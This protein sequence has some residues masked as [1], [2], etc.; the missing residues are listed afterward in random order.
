MSGPFAETLL[1]LAGRIRAREVTSTAVTE[2]CL[3]RIARGNARVNAF[4]TVSAEQALAMAHDA[5]REIAL[6]RYRGPLHGVPVSFKDLVDV[7]GMPT[8]AASRLLAGRVAPSDAPVAARLRAAGAVFLGKTNLHEFAFG[9]TSEDSAYGPVRNPVDPSR[10]AGGSSGGAAAA[11]VEGMGYAAIGTDTG[12]S[13]RI[14]AAACGCVGLKPTF[15]EIACD[16]VIPLS[17]SLD[18]VG[19][20]AGS[21]GGARAT[22]EAALG[23]PPSQAAPPPLASLRIG[24]LR[25]Y[26]TE[27]LDEDVRTAFEAVLRRLEAAGAALVERAVP[28][29]SDVASIYL[30]VQLP[31]ASA[32]HAEAI[33]QHPDAYTK[34]VRLRLEMGR[35]VLA[36]D[37]VR[38][39]RGAL[40]L[41]QEVSAALDGCDAL[42]LPTLP[43]PAPPLGVDAVMIGHGSQPVRALMLRLTQL[44]DITRHP[45]ISLPCGRTPLGLPVGLQLAGRLDRT[46]E[47]LDVAE[48]IEAL[49]GTP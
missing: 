30:H 27:L 10:S 37:Y 16:G 42:A 29:A 28:H 4:I 48:A 32:Y 17:W 31:E 12:G 40:L 34:P 9:T 1:Q 14:P 20:L 11:L 19:P 49:I 43:I 13:I 15:G 47:L 25:G 36:E 2:A 46:R 44:F 21:V 8:T 26:F 39:Q 3:D 18:H 6:G 24:V 38:A 22:Y 33:E 7:A 35:F 5:D 45:A 23:L 41:R